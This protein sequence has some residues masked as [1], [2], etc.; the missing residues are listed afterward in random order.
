MNFMTAKLTEE[1]RQ[2]LAQQPG[3]PLQ[4]EDPETHARYVLVKLDVYEQLQRAF[5]HDASDPDP[6]D[7]YPAFAQAV[8]DD[9]DAPGME[10]YDPSREWDHP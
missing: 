6:R 5:D 1:L 9:L 4:I 7:F 10:R 8:S 2:A 3:E